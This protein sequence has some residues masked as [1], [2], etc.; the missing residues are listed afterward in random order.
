MVLRRNP[1]YWKKDEKG[2]GYPYIEKWSL[3]IVPDKN[4][5]YLLFKQGT[6]DSYNL[7]AEDL[8]ELLAAEKPDY[9][10]F[11]GGES[12]GSAFFTFNQNPAHMDPLRYK[13]FSQTKFRQAMSSLLNRE[14][15][16]SQV[17]RGLAVPA[18]HFFAKPNPFYD[19][20]IRLPYTY[21][22]ARA[23][24]LLDGD[25]HQAERGGQDDRRRGQPRSSSRSTSGPRTTSASTSPTSLPTSST[26]RGSRP[27]CGRSTS[28]S[29]S[30]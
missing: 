10:V 19:E 2:T 5:E 23:K 11:N 22:P 13:W 28:R 6:R 12:L 20:S 7:R 30:R 21:D 26:R 4:T 18:H 3:R 9:T 14:R 1:N 16:V 27:T 24:R 15:I 25:R 17:Y 29:W 8:D